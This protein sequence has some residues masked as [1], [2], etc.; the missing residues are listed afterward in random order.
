MKS[1]LALGALLW[2][3]IHPFN[4][5]NIRKGI[6]PGFKLR[7][8]SHL[9]GLFLFRETKVFPE[10]IP[11]PNPEAHTLTPA[12]GA[13]DP[14]ARPTQSF[15][16]K[17]LP[18]RPLGNCCSS[19]APRAALGRGPPGSPTLMGERWAW[20]TTPWTASRWDKF[21]SATCTSSGAFTW[22]GRWAGLCSR[23]GVS[24]SW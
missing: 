7:A 3:P 10:S 17:L 14:D 15:P 20:P 6:H 12:P 22:L 13:Q 23:G 5:P 11:S 4:T 2:G 9:P 1:A 24:S 21:L 18:Y 19:E 8:H 16:P